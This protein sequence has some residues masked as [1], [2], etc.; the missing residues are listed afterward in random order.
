[1]NN[2]TG[3]FI[4]LEGI[5]GAGKST[6]R[7]FIADHLEKA[8]RDVVMTR[9]P[10][11]TALGEEIRKTLLMQKSLEI[12]SDT[13]LLLM[14]AARAQHLKGV[15]Y[16]ALAEGKTVLCDRFTDSSYAYQ[17]GGRGVA[18][19]KIQRLEQWLH[20]DLKP[21]LT[22]L[23]DLPVEVGLS[24]ANA[25]KHIDRFESEAVSFFQRVRK[26]YLDLA[27]TNPERIRI[28]NAEADINSVQRSIVM[29]LKE[30]GLC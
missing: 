30:Q 25:R 9:E 15:I 10:G 2:R 18:I 4:T 13:E 23:F 29:L 21:D 7:P 11:G 26:T 14:F 5:E 27:N 19:D 28:I 12:D 20:A 22:F 6:H 1:M 17:G 3:K 8:G 24:R 16:P